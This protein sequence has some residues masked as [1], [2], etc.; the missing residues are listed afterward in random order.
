[1]HAAR[2]SR[3]RTELH[4]RMISMRMVLPIGGLL[5]LAA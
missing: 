2:Y 4:D 3:G 5:M 1:M